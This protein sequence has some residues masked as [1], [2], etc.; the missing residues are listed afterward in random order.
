MAKISGLLTMN[1]FCSILVKHASS[2]YL[3][4]DVSK[5]TIFFDAK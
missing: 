1:K 4:Y 5:G 2:H 3:L